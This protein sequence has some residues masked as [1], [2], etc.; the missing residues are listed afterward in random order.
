MVPR[1]N[2]RAL[3]RPS[4]PQHDVTIAA[5]PGHCGNDVPEED[6]VCERNR[7]RSFFATGPSPFSRDGSVPEEF[8]LWSRQT[9]TGLVR[10][11]LFCRTFAV[12]GEKNQPQPLSLGPFAKANDHQQA[13]QKR[14]MYDTADVLRLGFSDVFL[15]PPHQQF[16]RAVSVIP[17]FPDGGAVASA[18]LQRASHGT[19]L[20]PERRRRDRE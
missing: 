18:V 15:Q 9:S 3:A 13:P 19:A 6:C 11:C 12:T 1:A 7:S 8:E 16:G 4:W 5:E 10:R 17:Y 14:T 20:Q 2:N